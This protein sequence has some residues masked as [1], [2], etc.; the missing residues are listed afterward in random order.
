L[1]CMKLLFFY[2]RVFTVIGLFLC[3]LVTNAVAGMNEF[4]SC[5]CKNGLASKGD[6]KE[7]VLQEC[8]QSVQIT[9]N[10]NRGCLEMWRYNFGPNE[11][12]QGICFDGSNKVKKVISLG[13]GY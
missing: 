7:E 1:G 8:G 5:R 10:Y 11:F 6:S 9:Y 3:A 4:D 2:L 13:R 12:M